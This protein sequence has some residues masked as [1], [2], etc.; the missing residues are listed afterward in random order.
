MVSSALV[1]LSDTS[2]AEE[3]EYPTDTHRKY[4]VTFEVSDVVNCAY[5]TADFGDGNVVDSRY[6]PSPEVT[7]I[8]SAGDDTT[9]YIAVHTYAAVPAAYTMVFTAYNSNGESAEKGLNVVLEGY[10]VI[11]FEANGGAETESLTVL[12]GADHGG[13]PE[14]RYYTAAEEPADPVR[15]GFDFTGWYTDEGLSQIYDWSTIVE[16]DVTLYAGWTVDV[17]EYTARFYVDRVLYATQ[18][19]GE[20]ETVVPPEPPSK[21]GFA[22]NGW[23]HYT[24]GMKATGDMGFCAI[25]ES[26]SP[27]TVTV[28]YTFEGRT[29]STYVETGGSFS[30]EAP[31]KEG[32]TFCG[33]YT[34]EACTQE[35]DTESVS[36]SVMIYP[37]F[38]ENSSDTGLPVIPIALAAAGMFAL[39]IGTRIHPAVSVIG[40]GAA[41]AGAALGFGI[42]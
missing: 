16:D 42:I 29:Y 39:F 36:E 24:E 12:N 13:L 26:E 28:T 23:K 14:N 4:T 18:T 15:E 31:V 17:P 9:D 20:G 25:F 19:Y 38:T 40:A 30:V 34:D 2:S 27:V 1:I 6:G 22:F 21:D 8:Y 10:P 3:N 35:F 32:C 33:W 5:Y 7:E 37:K 41:I 11:S